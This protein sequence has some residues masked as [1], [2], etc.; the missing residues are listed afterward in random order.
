MQHEW[1]DSKPIYWQ[2][3]D[4]T[5]ALILDG[6]LEQ[7]DALPSVRQVA[8][9]FQLNPITVSKAYQALVDEGVVE[10]KRGLGMF[11]CDGAREKLLDSE[12][13]KFL[14][15]EWPLVVRRIQR[16]GLD[17]KQLI[18]KLGSDL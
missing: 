15:D 9:E 8:A 16:L 13:Q 6:S 18:K 10:K 3:R 5:I 17:I 14:K 7:G 4:R 11:V 12:R 1:N 2:L